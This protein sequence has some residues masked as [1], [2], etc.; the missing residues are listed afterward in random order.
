[1]NDQAPSWDALQLRLTRAPLSP[2]GIATVELAIDKAERMLGLSW[3]SRQF[4]RKG[5]WP[6]EFNLLMFHAAALPQFLALVMRLES[7]VNEPTFAAVLRGLKRGVTS[8]DWRHALRQL[9]VHRAPKS[10]DSHHLRTRDQ[11]QP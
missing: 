8:T 6:G 2:D 11:R 10:Q 9:E 4:E 1:V 5:W 3:P 7:A